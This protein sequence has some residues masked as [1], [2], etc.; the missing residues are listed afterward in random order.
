MLRSKLSDMTAL[1]DPLPAPPS[2]A[3]TTDWLNPSDEKLYELID[4]VPVEKRVSY[5]SLMIATRIARLIGNYAE[6]K[7][8]GTL[9]TEVPLS[10]IFGRSNHG[11]RPD[12]C[13]T[14]FAAL[15]VV[16]AAGD[17]KGVVP[18]FVAEVVSPHDV[19]IELEIKIQEYLA[20]GIKVVWI[21]YPDPKV[22]RVHHAD[23]TMKLLNIT[24]TLDGGA[25]LPGF[26][27]VVADI[28]PKT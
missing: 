22:V 14:S 8:L 21:V 9:A 2:A 15:P 7:N 18:D 24:G 28:F 16:P 20:A 12:V 13:Y 25:A 26:T 11:R 4:G 27:C 1:T 6:P 17:L 5:L 23:G 3:P 10:G 19:A